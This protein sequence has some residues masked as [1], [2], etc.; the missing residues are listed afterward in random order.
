[1]ST[2]G[3]SVYFHL[4]LQ[5]HPLEA[6]RLPFFTL[7]SFFLQLYLMGLTAFVPFD[8]PGAYLTLTLKSL[9]FSTFHTNLLVIPSSVLW[10]IMVSRP[11]P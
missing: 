5:S 7:L 11:P 3:R 9:G 8:P 10:I 4:N 1:M 2:T 6:D